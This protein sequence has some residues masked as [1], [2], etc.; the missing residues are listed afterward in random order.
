MD[1]IKAQNYFFH[2]QPVSDHV[3]DKQKEEDHC[4]GE[5]AKKDSQPSLQV[6]LKSDSF[7][8]A[9]WQSYPRN[10]PLP[11]FFLHPSLAL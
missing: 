11:Y 10:S 2:P 7:R 1:A 5:E 6:Q 4:W 8:K 9:F 3:T